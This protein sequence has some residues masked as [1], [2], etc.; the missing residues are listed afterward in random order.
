MGGMAIELWSYLLS[1]SWYI[2]GHGQIQYLIG[3]GT[4]ISWETTGE[5][6]SGDHATVH[7]TWAESLL[8]PHDEARV[9]RRVFVAI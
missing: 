7:L 6:I 1:R 3:Q 4:V 9:L 5:K 8:I 2:S